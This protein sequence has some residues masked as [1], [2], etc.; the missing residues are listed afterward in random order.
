MKKVGLLIAIVAMMFSFTS[1]MDRVEAG[2]VGVKVNLLGENKGVQTE[3][4][5]VG[6]YWIGMNDQLFIFPVSQVNYVYT[7]D[8]TEGSEDNEEFTFQTKEGINCSA[9]LGVALSFNA[10][11]ITVMFQKYRKGVDEIRSVVVRNEIRDVLNR[12][13]SSMNTEDVYGI[14]KAKLIDS[15]QS[16]VK[17]N[18]AVNGIIIDKVSLIGSIRIPSTI[19]EALNAKVQM[20]QDAQRSENQVQKARA[21][22]DIRT[23]NAKGE[24]DALKIQADGQ[25][26]YNKTVSASITQQLIDMKKIDKWNGINSTTILSGSGQPIVNLK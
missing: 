24:A 20:T 19:L 9:D 8:T 10:D 22:A 25:A 16:I 4:L 23:A 26:Y 6:R 12:V 14:G 2:Q 11:K 3:T 13:A 5:G 17:H 1:C 18:L 21:E 7:K 15:V